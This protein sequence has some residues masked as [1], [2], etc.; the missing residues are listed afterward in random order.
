MPVEVGGFN[1]LEVWQQADLPGKPLAAY[2]KMLKDILVQGAVQ[3]I[4]EIP[5]VAVGNDSC[6]TVTRVMM[7]FCSC[8]LLFVLHLLFS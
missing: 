4:Q 3:V 2:D 5:Q 8:P 1:P 6:G 7:E